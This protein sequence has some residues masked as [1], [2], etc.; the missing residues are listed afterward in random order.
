[1]H[2]LIGNIPIA[3]DVL[4]ALLLGNERDLVARFALSWIMTDS[5]SKF[6][7]DLISISFPDLDLDPT[8]KILNVRGQTVGPLD[9]I[10]KP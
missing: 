3:I 8:P 2:R 4:S 5:E 6:D 1:M 10:P 7:L 9:S